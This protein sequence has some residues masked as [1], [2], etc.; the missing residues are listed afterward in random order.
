MA[1]SL[2]LLVIT[3]SL[4]A[5]FAASAAAGASRL[6]PIDAAEAVSTHA[7]FE[8][9]ACAACHDESERTASSP[10]RVLKVSNDLCFDCH[11]EYRGQVRRHPA[12]K[13]TCVGCHSPHNAR[14]RKLLL[15][16]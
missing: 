6:A 1:D 14:K 4:G 11:E 12:P 5:G 13:G 16:S 9:G 15:G 8:M 10:G 2:R 7:P 3:V